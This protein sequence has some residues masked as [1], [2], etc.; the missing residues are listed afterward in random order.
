MVWTEFTGFVFVKPDKIMTV[1]AFDSWR[2]RHHLRELDLIVHTSADTVAEG[3]LSCLRP[4]N[5][6]ESCKYFLPPPMEGAS[7]GGVM[8]V[9]S[10]PSVPS[11]SVGGVSAGVSTP[12]VGSA[13]TDHHRSWFPPGIQRTH[14]VE[15]LTPLLF[16]QDDLLVSRSQGYE[17]G[18]YLGGGS[19][20][21]VYKTRS[22]TGE[23]VVVKILC[24][25][26]WGTTSERQ[27]TM[28][29]VYVLERCS[30]LHVHI[31]RVLDVFL[32]KKTRKMHIVMELWGE[33]LESYRLRRGFD[34]VDPQSTTHIRT[35][36]LHVCRALSYLH[37]GLGMCHTDVKLAN[38]LV[39]D[40]VDCLEKGIECKL[41]DVGSVEEV[42]AILSPSRAGAVILHTTL[43][44][45]NTHLCFQAVAASLTVTLSSSW[46]SRFVLSV[47]WMTRH[48]H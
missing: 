7:A 39:I 2:A 18:V 47:S 31:V 5:D 44:V 23:D 43:E 35:F 33:S 25:A 38:I 27:R 34:R 15:S 40:K 29:E 22:P 13:T 14:I 19:F 1:S 32:D 36:L 28:K 6:K 11:Q 9:G 12:V 21:A 10:Q 8:S 3:L 17:I 4:Q 48:V 16:G 26:A 42:T 30:D 45:L 46:P 24:K 41:A 20:G 37:R